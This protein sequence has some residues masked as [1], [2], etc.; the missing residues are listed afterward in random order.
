MLQRAH[1][2]YLGDRVG[3]DK[4]DHYCDDDYYDDDDN[5]DFKMWQGSLP[6]KN[7]D[8][9]IFWYLERKSFDWYLST[10]LLINRFSL[11]FQGKL[12]LAVFKKAILAFK[13]KYMRASKAIDA[14]IFKFL[15]QEDDDGKIQGIGRLVKQV[16]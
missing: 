11:S 14:R 13:M 7:V 8:S 1:C 15:R 4:I 9:L 5:T 16:Q 3:G 6:H 2:S 12:L 10:A